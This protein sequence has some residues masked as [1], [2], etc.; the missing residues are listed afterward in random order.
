[1]GGPPP[2]GPA[3]GCV[4]AEMGWAFA[5]SQP[6]QELLGAVGAAAETAFQTLLDVEATSAS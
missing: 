5:S 6:S 2:P 4:S 3:L 1:M